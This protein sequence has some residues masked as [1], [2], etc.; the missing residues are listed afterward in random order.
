MHF[1]IKRV[2]ENMSY[3]RLALVQSV[4][5]INTTTARMLDSMHPIRPFH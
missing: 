3:A 2:G 5:L 1:L 4:L